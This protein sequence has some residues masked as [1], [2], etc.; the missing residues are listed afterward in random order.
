MARLDRCFDIED[1]RKA[2]KPRL[3]R[4]V[5]EFVERGVEDEVALANNRNAF[6]RIKLLN[7]IM[8][9]V[10]PTKTETTLFG[11]PMAMPY[12]IS[13]TGLAG[14]CWFE[15]ELALAKAAAKA[16]IPCTLATGSVTPMEQLAKEVPNGRLWFQLYMWRDRALSHGLVQRARD[17]GFEALL[18]TADTGLGANRAHN[19][20]NG[21]SMPFRFSRYNVP[22]L[23]CHPGWLLRVMLPYVLKSGTPRHENYPEGHRKSI[24]GKP[25]QNKHAR[26]EDMTWKDLEAL[27]K[28]WPGPLLVKGVLRVDDARLA[29]ENGA[30]GI[31]VSNH[32][33]R[34]LDSA[35]ATMDMLPAIV[36]AVGNKTTVILDSGARRGSDIVKGLALGAKAVMA[37]RPTLYGMAVG[38]EAGASHALSLLKTEMIQT[39]GYVGARNVDEITRDIIGV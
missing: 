9:D 10:T 17:A 11:K 26:G 33:G 1:L 29:V 31:V 20:R 7:R 28:L 13:P 37:G 6:D 21:F 27:R 8:V 25:G 19:A 23:A 39:M 30:D 2:A 12:A 24:I 35:S 18:V 5:Y 16:G 32:G 14:L 34:Q 36:D 38:G 4:V 22:D 3:P 15:G